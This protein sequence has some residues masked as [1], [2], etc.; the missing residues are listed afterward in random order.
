MKK[1][2]LVGI[3]IILGMTISMITFT[4]ADYETDWYW[5][6][7][8]HAV[9]QVNTELPQYIK[10]DLLSIPEIVSIEYRNKNEHIMVNVGDLDYAPSAVMQYL[11]GMIIYMENSEQLKKFEKQSLQIFDRPAIR[12]WVDNAD[13]SVKAMGLNNSQVVYMPNEDYRC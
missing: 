9:F 13:G 3:C 1:T 10:D 6:N 8:T 11:N 12:C 2:I 7:S 4:Q 5:H